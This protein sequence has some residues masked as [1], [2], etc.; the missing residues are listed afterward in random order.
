METFGI[1]DFLKPLI[2]F[3]QNTTA[4]KENNEPSFSSAQSS[5]TNKNLG[6]T[7]QEER[8]NLVPLNPDLSTNLSPS[9]TAILDFYTAHEIRA[10]RTRK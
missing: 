3:T 8:E 2:D 6:D 5:E 7:L 10:K 1:L 9:Q 4:K